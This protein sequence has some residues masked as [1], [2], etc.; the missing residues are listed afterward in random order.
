MVIAPI[1]AC[2]SDRSIRAN[3]GLSGTG[4]SKNANTYAWI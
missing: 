3:D 4:N 2:K 1:S